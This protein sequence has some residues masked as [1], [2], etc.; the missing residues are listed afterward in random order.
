VHAPP[1]WATACRAF[2]TGTGIFGMS[3]PD[4]RFARPDAGPSDPVN[5][6]L[7]SL[8][9]LYGTGLSALQ[10]L[11]GGGAEGGRRGDQSR[12]LF[13]AVLGP[14]AEMAASFG[15]ML[16]GSPGGRGAY[17]DAGQAA[18]SQ[19]ADMSPAMAQACMLAIG[20]TMRYLR[21]LAELHARYQ[22]S[23]MQAVADRA[24]GQA[25]ASPAECRVLA[26]ELRAF[27]R[28]VGDAATLEARRLQ[29]ELEQ[30]GESIAHAADHATSSPQHQ[31]RP[32]RRPHQVKE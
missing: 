10:M 18:V 13:S 28:E 23:L 11:A 20:S 17:T 3:G 5:N 8:L 31:P 12:S 4:H 25:A 21:A 14:M 2:A 19:V 27:L 15:A 7:A 24:T 16:P 32:H 30:V 22:A 9:D 29:S 1:L 26:D 6:F